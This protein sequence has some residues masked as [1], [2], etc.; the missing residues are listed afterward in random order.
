MTYDYYTVYE[1]LELWPDIEAAKGRGAAVLTPK[2]SRSKKKVERKQARER[3]GSRITDIIEFSV[4]IDTAMKSVLSPTERARLKGRFYYGLE[5]NEIAEN[6]G[7]TAAAVQL[8]CERAIRKMSDYLESPK[9][10]VVPPYVKPEQTH[11]RKYKA[12]PI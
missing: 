2:S 8:S 3:L 4:D 9:V 10:S 7:I 11:R 1:L 6:L 12:F 5:Y